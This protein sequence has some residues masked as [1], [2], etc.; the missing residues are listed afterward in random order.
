MSQ[1]ENNDNLVILVDM[2][3]VLCDFDG[4]WRRDWNK[5][6]PDK[7]ITEEP[8][9]FYLEEAY[10]SFATEEEIV[11]IF[12]RKGF[13]YD[14]DPMPG[15]I[16]AMRQMQDS[17]LN[18]FICTAPMGSNTFMEKAEWVEHYLGKEWLKRLVITKDKTLVH[19]NYLIDDKPE[20][21]GFYDE[22]TWEHVVYDHPYN[23]Y[24]TDKHRITWANWPSLLIYDANKSR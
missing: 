4:G 23:Q 18:V 17:G 3:G 13:F 24:L 19:G 21:T 6:Y 11:A 15:A 8:T 5:N 14:L 7:P 16:E 2:D 10:S 9:S 20:L 22:P 1:N 12:N